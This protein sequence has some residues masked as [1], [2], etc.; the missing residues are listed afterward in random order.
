MS[1]NNMSINTLTTYL[2]LAFLLWKRHK[3]MDRDRLLLLSAAG[4]CLMGL[5]RI[6]GYCRW[7][8]L[9]HNPGHMIG[10]WDTVHLGLHNEELHSLLRQVER[11][12]TLERIESE[13]QEL[14]FV[15]SNERS[16]YFS[17]EEFMASIL[18]IGQRWLREHFDREGR[19]IGI[20]SAGEEGL[21]E[22]SE[23]WG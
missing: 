22:D 13:L 18:G 21:A 9:K 23:G 20:E 15:D 3:L 7:L 6:A 17:D 16:T 2:R 11:R 12:F 4:A 5:H 14:G 8:I 10:N 1:L 19:Y